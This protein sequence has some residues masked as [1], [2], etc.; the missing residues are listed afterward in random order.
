MGFLSLKMLKFPSI[1][2]IETKP[3]KNNLE[4]L[5]VGTILRS[6]QKENGEP[7]NVVLGQISKEL[8]FLQRQSQYA[9]EIERVLKELSLTV[10]LIKGCQTVVVPEGTTRQELLAYYQGNFFTLVHQMK[11]KVLHLVN[12][13]TETVIPEEPSME[14]KDISVTDLFKNKELILDTIGIKDAIKEWEQDNPTSWIA[15]VLRKRSHHHH[16]ISGLKYDKD[17]LNLGFTD[18]ATQENVQVS[19]SEYSKE[20]IEKMRL[21]SSER[22][23]SSALSKAES[24]FKKIEENIEVVSNALVTHFKLPISQDEISKIITEHGE[25]LGSFEIKNKCSIDKV[26]EPHKT[27]LD[28]LVEKMKKEYGDKV[29]AVYLVGSLPRGEYEEGYSDI[30]LYVVLN[31]DENNQHLKDGSWFNLRVL[32]QNFF[33]SEAGHKFRIIA[34]ADGVLLYGTDLVADEKLPKAGL[35]LALIL[36]G[37]ILEILDEAKAWMEANPNASQDQISKKSRKLAKRIIDFIYGVAMSNKP[38]FTA[39]REER[40]EKILESFPDK[41]VIDTLMGMTRY[42]VGEFESFKNTFEGIRPNAE[43]NLKKM[44][45]VKIALEKREEDKKAKGSKV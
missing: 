6:F 5:K 29:V 13:M 38:Q 45:D 26:E 8:G 23:F 42:G 41:N 21:E 24:T 15:V 40:V 9:G 33:L 36:F 20:Q 2:T 19:L 44:T 18:I 28:G 7:E 27:I 4:K 32:S 25:M 37:D 34:K 14:K 39:S 35:F 43:E 16:K 31:V 30:N 22:L 12:L 3:Y 1:M 10:T 11:D 17:Y